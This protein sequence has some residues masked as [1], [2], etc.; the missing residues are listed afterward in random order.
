MESRLASTPPQGAD[1][2]APETAPQSDTESRLDNV[3]ANAEGG[4][5][6][7]GTA[8][9]GEGNPNAGEGEGGRGGEGA[10]RPARRRPTAGGSAP[11]AGGAGST[12]GPASEF[13]GL[14][15]EQV[16]EY[17]AG[18]VSP[19]RAAQFD[20]VTQ[21]LLESAQTLSER[22]L[23]QPDAS[24]LGETNT[25]AVAQPGAA[26]SA[27]DQEEPWLRTVAQIRDVTGSLGGV[28]GMIGLAA[29]VSGLILSLLIPPVGAFLLTVGR[30]CDVAALIL[31]AISLVLSALLTGYNLYRLKNAT[32]PA[33]K[34]RLLGLVR[35][36]AMKTVMSGIAVA[37]AVA[38][39]A[40]RAL[41]R[42]RAGQAVGRGLS[43]VARGGGRGLGRVAAAAGRLPGVGGALT[44]IGQGAASVGR[45]TAGLARAAGARV[46][47]GFH[48]LMGR[49]RDTRFLTRLNQR[50][51][52]TEGRILQGLGRS[53]VGQRLGAT[54]LGANL[55][56]SYRSNRD[57][58]E[59]LFEGS[60]VRHHRYVG[61]RL[62]TELNQLQQ[63][64]AVTEA[65]ARQRLSQRYREVDPNNLTFTT[66]PN[67]GGRL[68]FDR[69]GTRPV[70]PQLDRFLTN[71][72]TQEQQA[73]QNAIA[74]N[75]TWSAD[76][77]ADFLNRRQNAPAF[78]TG[79][80]I[81]SFRNLAAQGRGAVFKTPHHTISV[82]DAPHLQF[83]PRY[84]QLANAPLVRTP[85][86]T[87]PRTA[88]D[89][90]DF[91]TGAYRQGPHS[92]APFVRR[93]AD[94]EA[95]V[96]AGQVTNITD[97]NYFRSDQF[98]RELRQQGNTGRWVNPHNPNQALL[99]DAHFVGGHRWQTGETGASRLFGT[100]A[101][102]EE[103][104]RGEATRRLGDIGVA[105]AGRWS[106]H[107]STSTR[108]ALAPYVDSA[109][110][111]AGAPTDLAP[112]STATQT[113]AAATRE[114]SPAATPGASPA[115]APSIPSSPDAGDHGAPGGAGGN[116]ANNSP[117]ASPPPG[118]G[119]TADPAPASTRPEARP[120]NRSAS[121]AF[122]ERLSSA[123]AQSFLPALQTHPGAP[124][125]E[126][127]QPTTTNDTPP[128]NSTAEPA[129]AP[130][131]E[132]PP[133]PV[134][135]SP[136]S[137]AHIRESRLS[138]FEAIQAVQEFIRTAAQA[139]Q[140]NTTAGEAAANLQGTL[141]TQ[142][143]TVATERAD[144][145]G[146]QGQLTQASGAQT[147][148]VAE[149]NRATSEANR[150]ESEGQ[151]VQAEGQEVTVAP[152]PEEPRERSWLERAW[153]ATAGALWDRLI[154]PA[155]RAVR[156]KVNQVMQ[157]INEFIMNMINQALGLD[158]IEAELDGGGQDISQRQESLTSTDEGLVSAD[159]QAEQEQQRNA[160]TQAQAEANASEAQTTRLDAEELLSALVEH[161]AA[162]EQEEN[163][164]RDFLTSFGGRYAPYFAREQQLNASPPAPT[165]SSAD[166][167]A[168]NTPAAEQSAEPAPPAEVVTTGHLAPTLGFIT[169]LA[170][171][172]SSAAA[173]VSG[174]A[175]D[176]ASA[177][178]ATNASGDP[179]GPAPAGVAQDFASGQSRRARRLAQLRH[180]ALACLGRP[181]ESS[182]GQL[183]ETM[184]AALALADEVEDGRQAALQRLGEPHTNAPTN[185]AAT[186]A[187]PA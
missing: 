92:S 38:P 97:P 122:I 117:P 16:G 182:L 125:V 145:T 186:A 17:L 22:Q 126:A 10:Q 23:V 101:R 62:Q 5:G 107:Y 35:E 51:L 133:T 64:G 164:G 136:E 104:L 57:L 138:V 154:A 146:Q 129:A 119:P 187:P 115:T 31:D 29:T 77:I 166:T 13:E 160:T 19:E 7:P 110:R 185:P 116:G 100:Y 142:R 67:A 99:F 59:V 172:D 27:Y 71:L 105:S 124:T 147:S 32:D 79:A 121:A 155:V 33:E 66:D 144:V 40:A 49:A 106:G 184:D 109:L 180:Q 2:S 39:G 178:A 55:R 4:E 132:S 168:A 1:T 83:D 150:G 93:A 130:E 176:S 84:I 174:L 95:L 87:A 18:N 131:L 34:R 158:E 70:S 152:K 102:L 118:A 120:A 68:Q 47:G 50:A 161:H 43:A 89:W 169:D 96:R 3:E 134:P 114:S 63:A 151:G 103:S 128:T 143:A 8:G 28:V 162:L 73:V 25:S 78:W 54:R 135:Y 74:G 141:T 65:T 90:E 85:R 179:A 26:T 113:Q 14:V 181:L 80:E 69:S 123:A 140:A 173:Q 76:Q 98:F 45:G 137:L 139:E 167:P 108:A 171:A 11:P 15:D 88:A 183:E 163:A 44:R 52:Q 20:P 12:P 81:D 153:D 157:S 6:T 24:S 37:T 36:D 175:T 82:M 177:L 86:V 111:R 21:Q 149:N 56:Q 159:Q 127:A 75:P 94:A 58:A 112:S 165:A 46:S 91:V 48:R 42:T 72:R 30:F 53:R 148:M 61:G 9:S 170:Q 41:G 60:Q 156:R